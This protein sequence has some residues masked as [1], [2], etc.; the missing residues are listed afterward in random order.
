MMIISPPCTIVTAYFRVEAESTVAMMVT[1]EG[2]GVGG[3]E[4]RPEHN[5]ES[6]F[7]LLTHQ[8][9]SC[10]LQGLVMTIGKSL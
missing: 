1:C 7:A 9:C 3:C 8:Q 2:E 10:H 4:V 6:Q 5:S